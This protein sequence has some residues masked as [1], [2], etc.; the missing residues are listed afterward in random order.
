MPRDEAY[1]GD[2]GTNYIYSRR[3]YKTTPL[4]SGIAL[5]EGACRSGHTRSCLFQRGHAET[6][7]QRRSKRPYRNGMDSVAL[8]ADAEPEMGP[9]IASLSMGVERLFRLKSAKRGC[10]LGGTVAAR[11]PVDHGGRNPEKL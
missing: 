4:D 9:V 5:L 10:R 7:L 1:Y 11:Q 8:H 3:E 2:P 6:G